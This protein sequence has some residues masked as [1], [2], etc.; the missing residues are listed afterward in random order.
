MPA[1]EPIL[2]RHVIWDH[3]APVVFRAIM[4]LAQPSAFSAILRGGERE[5]RCCRDGS[6]SPADAVDPTGARPDE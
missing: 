5:C 2:W 1:R 4:V 6:P 3:L